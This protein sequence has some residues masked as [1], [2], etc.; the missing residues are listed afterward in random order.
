VFVLMGLLLRLGVLLFP[1]GRSVHVGVGWRP[2]R[3]AVASAGLQ[4]KQSLCKV[5]QLIL[6][7][8]VNAALHNTAA[9][10]LAAACQGPLSALQAC[11]QCG[12]PCCCYRCA[13]AQKCCI[14]Q[15]IIAAGAIHHKATDGGPAV[16]QQ[17]RCM[18]VHA[19]FGFHNPGTCPAARHAQGYAAN[20]GM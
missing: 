8:P 12:C 2:A 1:G 20:K 14:K 17:S 9:E 11:E 13:V 3:A 6:D 18:S 16:Q 4:M 15:R 19:C 5:A 10:A 7:D